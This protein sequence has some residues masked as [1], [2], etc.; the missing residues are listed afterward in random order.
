MG[1]GIASRLHCEAEI[2]RYQLSTFA[3]FYNFCTLVAYAHINVLLPSIRGGGVL[4]NLSVFYPVYVSSSLIY[5][6]TMLLS[7]LC[8][9]CIKINGRIQMLT[10]HPMSSLGIACMK[11]WI[12]NPA[13]SIFLYFCSACPYKNYIYLRRYGLH[14]I[15]CSPELQ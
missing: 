11:A 9:C 4:R 15:R 14:L 12:K 2:K 6:L 10:N 13:F 7:C 5:S 3:I 8:R 1:Y